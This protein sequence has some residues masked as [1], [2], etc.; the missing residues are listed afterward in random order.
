MAFEGHAHVISLTDLVLTTSKSMIQMT[1]DRTESNGEEAARAGGGE[2]DSDAALSSSTHTRIAG[3][4]NGLLLCLCLRL[5]L[6]L[7]RFGET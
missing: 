3:V 5:R 2:S 7:R 4:G 6:R 1:I